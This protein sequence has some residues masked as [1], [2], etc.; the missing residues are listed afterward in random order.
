MKELG[1]TAG[2]SLCF[3]FH[4]VPFGDF[5]LEPQPDDLSISEMVD[6]VTLGYWGWSWIPEIRAWTAKGCRQS[7]GAHAIVFLGGGPKFPAKAAG[8]LH[9]VMFFEG[10]GTLIKLDPSAEQKLGSAP[11]SSYGT[12]TRGQ[13]RVVWLLILARRGSLISASS[14]L[15][16]GGSP[17]CSALQRSGEKSMH[18]LS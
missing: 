8:Q 3:H 5:F 17:N 18:E 16:H 6:L 9:L 10:T 4:L 12:N 15:T 7:N 11:S 13:F 1:P 14:A 2:V